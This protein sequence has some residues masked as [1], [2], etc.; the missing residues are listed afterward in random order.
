MARVCLRAD[1]LS[2]SFST[3]KGEVPVLEDVNLDVYENELVSVVGPSGC[4]KSTLL[5]IAA[6]LEDASGGRITLYGES[7]EGPDP[8]RG[9]VFQSYT[10]FPWAT[11]RENVEF[12]PKMSGVGKSSRRAIADHFLEEVGLTR[13]AASYPKQLSGGMRQR[14]AIARALANNPAVLLMDEPFGALDAQ[15]RQNMQ[16]LL[17]RIRAEEQTTILFITHDIDEAVYLSDRIYVM[18]QRPGRI[19]E[20]IIV[21]FDPY[22]PRD[23][24]LRYTQGFVDLCRKVHD[25]LVHKSGVP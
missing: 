8:E 19:K 9:V 6:G 25:M 20:E 18:T 12:G 21:S 24:E 2:K 16:E 10:L 15:T 11:V 5:S 14:V 3:A 1:R 23:S 7:F 13:F 4:G 22:G 17:L